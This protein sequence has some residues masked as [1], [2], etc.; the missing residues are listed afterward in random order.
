M[1]VDQVSSLNVSLFP[2]AAE[3]TNAS[4]REETVYRISTALFGT[5][6]RRYEHQNASNLLATIQHSSFATEQNRSKGGN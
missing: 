4:D 5:E 1:A 3:E 6:E 2:F